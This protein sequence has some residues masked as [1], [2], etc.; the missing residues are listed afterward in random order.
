MPKWNQLSKSPRKRAGDYLKLLM[1][2][3]KNG[4]FYRAIYGT[5][6]AIYGTKLAVNGTIK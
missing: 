3:S 5:K 6:W 1:I 4:N 2:S